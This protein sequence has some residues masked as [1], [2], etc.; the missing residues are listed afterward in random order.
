MILNFANKTTEDIYNGLDS[1]PARRIPQV[2]WKIAVRKLDMLN[3][4]HDRRDLRIP[5][6]NRLEALKGD[7]AGHHSIRVN[8]QYRIVFKWTEGN[9]KDVQITN[10]H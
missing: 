7:W 4:A 5:P 10:Y 9:A 8:D 3:A 6:A 1:K 2:V